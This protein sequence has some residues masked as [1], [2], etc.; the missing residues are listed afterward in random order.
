MTAF[1]PIAFS[2]RPDLRL[3][4]AALIERGGAVFEMT[5][6]STSESV[7]A[8]ESTS[9]LDAEDVLQ[10]RG[11]DEQAFERIVRRYQHEISRRLQRFSRNTLVHEELI[12]E[13][14]VQAFLGLRTYR[15]D[16]PLIHWLHRIAVRVGYRYWRVQRSRP[17]HITLDAQALPAPIA[18]EPVEL[19]HV[20]ERLSARDRLVLTLVYL[21]ER[22]VE[23]TAALTGW[24]RTMVKVQSHRARCRL[25]KLMEA[26][27]PGEHP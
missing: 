1:P 3:W 18:R 2:A 4:L 20:L 10:A 12:Q 23:E 21:E 13:T 7:I 11:G 9:D 26:L 5:A 22:S 24:S 16:G 8:H 15:A 17:P 6:N 27:S 19:Y 25:R 14:F